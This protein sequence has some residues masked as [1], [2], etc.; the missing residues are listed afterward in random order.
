MAIKTLTAKEIK[1][2]LKTNQDVLKDT[3]LEKLVFLVH[4]LK[5]NKM[6]IATS[7]FLSNLKNQIST[8][9]WI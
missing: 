7:I 1:E 3:M 6:R 4:T 8:I 5:E 2:I 9:L